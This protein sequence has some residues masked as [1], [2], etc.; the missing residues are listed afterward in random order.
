MIYSFGNFELD[1]ARFE[2]RCGGQAVVVQ[3]KV[4]RLLLL[5]VAQRHRSVSE[6]ELMDTL[7]P[8]ETVGRASITRAIMGA[9]VALDDR[10]Q[11]CIRTLRGYGYQFVA[12]V[13]ERESARPPSAPPQQ[14]SPE[15]STQRLVGREGV[16]AELHESL[17]AALAGRGHCVLI[18]GEPGMGKTRLLHELSERASGRG[19]RVWFG[20]CMEFEG[21]P[22]FWPLQQILRDAL[23]DHGE[24]EL[25]AL[26]GPGAADIAQGFPELRDDLS[27]VDRSPRIAAVSER[28][29]LFDSTAQ[30][31]LRAA[32]EA[33]IVMLLDDLQKADQ[34]TLRLLTFL[35]GQLDQ[36]RLLVV[37][38]ARST[39]LG[40]HEAHERLAEL[41]RASA[42]RSIALHG[43]S[44]GEIARYL[45][46]RT[47]ARAPADLVARM[48]EQTA[49]NPLFLQEILRSLR[50]VD[51][52]ELTRPS[53]E[54][55][56]QVG[57]SRG[58][59]GAIERHLAALTPPTRAL[60]AAASV[61]GREFSVGLLTQCS[62]A[63]A[64]T[65][66]SLLSEAASAGIVHAAGSRSQYR[67]THALIRDALYEATEPLERAAQHARVGR[68][69]EARGAAY[70][71]DAELAQMAEHF[72]MAA[73]THD[74]GRALAYEKLAA[75]RALSR[76]AY[77]EA[78]EHYGRAL[79]L[80]EVDAAERMQLLLGRGSAL[81]SGP[82]PGSARSSLLQAVTLARGLGA[83]DVIA[84]AARLLRGPRESGS[85]DT[86]QI[87]LLR[88]ALAA[89]PRS[90]ARAP[91]LQALLAKALSFTSAH[92][93][94]AQLA[95]SALAQIESVTAPALRA[96]TLHACHEAL[97]DPE[98][99]PQRITIARELS[100]LGQLHADARTMVYALTSHFQNCV[101]QGD[102]A[103]LELVIDSLETLERR[104]RDPLIRWYAQ[105]YRSTCAMIAGR[106]EIA[107]QCAR[108]ALQLGR[109]FGEEL[110]YHH[111]CVQMN[112]LLRLQGRA[113]EAE[114][115]AC[116]MS[117]QYPS[118][119]GW[120]AFVGAIH[121]DAGR[122][123]LARQ[124]YVQLVDHELDSLRRDPYLLSALCPV[125]ELGVR[126]GDRASARVLYDALLPY[127][128]RHGNV[129]FGAAT[130]GP[131]S[132]QLARLAS[133]IGEL[134]LA[135]GHCE[136]ALVEAERMPSRT[137]VALA[138][139]SYA[140]ILRRVDGQ[141]ARAQAY[142]TRA[143][144]LACSTGMHGMVAQCRGLAELLAQP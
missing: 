116:E 72:R 125:A 50:T 62:D 71:Q 14:T 141:G 31:F 113:A 29:R 132:L 137:F 109:V 67:F 96:E 6:Q 12:E 131:V 122:T 19:M 140:H 33:P 54:S 112:G 24:R 17:D 68:A 45:E 49:G 84:Q 94:R 127:E 126:V 130:Y 80:A 53:W 104:V 87:A 138:C 139:L 9:R 11:G 69:L 95:L 83:I 16:L 117:A 114:A 110:A 88:E 119:A 35:T 25:T 26:L 133:R 134:T 3:P 21:A 115:M 75:E 7:W 66:V 97:T 2:L 27:Q 52:G 111:F 65:V 44:V 107:E 143:L 73:P 121:A 124:I 38:T 51:A 142:L 120:R 86:V 56:S 64:D 123:A 74:G 90:D 129:S 102:V 76:L 92:T 100:Q 5:L 48:H 23:R 46:L 89:L 1:Q 59:R 98:Y 128:G 20:R 61:M 99:L 42:T 101:E 79:Q 60:L 28:F 77:E 10:G 81:A 34:P 58:V 37:G 93:E 13:R 106:F 22:P 85:T 118:L 32:R 103:A 4:L 78:A 47:G 105:M 136:R 41:S 8:D 70:G 39:S 55:L 30:F 82:E 135:E 57:H 108:A 63:P 91:G 43:L 36:A 15:S 18:F 40:D 144:E